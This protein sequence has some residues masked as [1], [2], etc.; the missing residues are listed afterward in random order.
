MNLRILFTIHAIITL[1][2]GI[3]LIVAPELIPK[4]VDI[5]IT[6]GEYLLS[7]F[8][9]AAELAI[10]FLSFYSRKINDKYALRIIVITFMIF[11]AATGL[12]EIYG[13]FQNVSLKIIGNIILRFAI[14]F[15]FY[16]YGIH[17]NKL[18]S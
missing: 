7:Y 9:G 15:L 6:S 8:L 3:V 14:V 11:H 18:E 2:A 17:K 4:T 5:T 16:Y 13:L 1:A 10:G 12:L